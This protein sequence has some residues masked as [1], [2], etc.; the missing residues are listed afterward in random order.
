[1]FTVKNKR[2]KI[3]KKII[4]S[5]AAVFAF[6]FANA[7]DVKYGVKGGLNLSTLN[8]D[9]DGAPSS[10]TLASINIGGFVEVKISDKF[11]IQPELVY[12]KQGNKMNF[13]SE[14]ARLNSFKLDYINIPVM[15]K[16]YVAQDFSIEMGPQIGFLTSAKVNGTSSGTTVEVDAKQFFKSVDFGVNLGASYDLTKKV[17]LGVRYNLGL[18]NIGS[19]EFVSDGE[20]ISNSVFSINLGYKF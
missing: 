9:G 12:S 8:F 16:Y 6:G 19:D 7:Q 2:I 14:G 11:S 5:V 10:N 15:A 1:M 3:M 18:A 13:E 4:L 20:K 17:S